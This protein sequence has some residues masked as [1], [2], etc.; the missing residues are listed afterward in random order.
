MTAMTLLSERPRAFSGD[1]SDVLLVAE[2]PLASWKAQFAEWLNNFE[3]FRSMEESAF[4]PDTQNPIVSRVHRG[5]IC[6]LIANAEMLATELIQ[7]DSGA[8]AK[9]DQ[10]RFVDAF[11]D[12][13]RSDFAVWHSGEEMEAALRSDCNLG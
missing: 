5:W 2:D 3:E 13:L 9:A 11:A 6:S 1:W 7:G 10:L 12:N 4:F 8:D